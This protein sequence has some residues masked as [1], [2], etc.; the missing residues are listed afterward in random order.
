MAVRFGIRGALVLDITL[1]QGFDLSRDHLGLALL[2]MF[3]IGGSFAGMVGKSETIASLAEKWETY[4]RL[5][6]LPHGLAAVG[7]TQAW[8]ESIDDL[9]RTPSINAME[10]FELLSAGVIE[11]LENQ[12]F[13]GTVA[14]V[15]RRWGLEI[16]DCAVAWD[17]GKITAG[18]IG[19]ATTHDDPSTGFNTMLT[20]LEIPEALHSGVLQAIADLR[21]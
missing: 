5:R 20:A 7:M 4:A 6:Q 10:G 13:Q 3:R 17:R 19:T 2:I 14:Y 15:E 12:S 11:L 8:R 21:F 18:P 16:V 1:E 9:T